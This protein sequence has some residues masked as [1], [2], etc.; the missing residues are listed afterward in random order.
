MKLI[1][2]V[3]YINGN[4]KVTIDLA[5]GTKIR[6]T[7][8]D[9]F[10]PDFAECCDV[11]ISDRCD[12]GCEFCYAGCSKDGEYGKLANWKFYDSLHPYTEM[13]IN[14]Q[15]PLPIHIVGFLELM[16]KKNIIVNVTVNQNH[17]MRDSFGEFLHRLQKKELIKGIGISLTNPTEEFIKK[18]KE[19]D[20]VVIHV[21]NGIVTTEQLRKLAYHG[22]KIL[23]LGYKNIGRGSSYVEDPEVAI[24]VRNRKGFLYWN[25][26]FILENGWF[27][28]V[29][30]DNLALDQ[31][32]M[33]RILTKEQ[34]EEFYMGDDGTSTFFINLVD[35]TFGKNSLTTK[36]ERMPIGD[37]SIDEM[38]EIVKGGMI[39][40]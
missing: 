6:E 19:F 18:T 16:K 36:E 25:I 22:M 28:T 12:N 26:K 29:A 24:H 5:T 30:F 11:H 1:N 37:K 39:S 38:F 14:L 31:L 23:I 13:A 4:V 15:A 8:D 40:G 34:W 32:N 2:P 3:T 27:D 21:I 7:E 9:E 17:F 35:G 33:R 10:R 20:N